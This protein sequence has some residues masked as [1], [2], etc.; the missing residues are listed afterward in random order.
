MVS[1]KLSI[2]IPAYNVEDYIEKCIT[3]IAEQ[4]V[5]N[6]FY[7][8]IIV[9][10]GST[11]NSRERILTL[12]VSYKNIVLVDQENKGVSMARNAGINKANGDYLVFVD[13]DDF[14]APG[15]L[16]SVLKHATF[17]KSQLTFLG[18]HSLEESI[19]PT[20]SFQFMQ[21]PSQ[22]LTGIE[23]YNTLMK[24]LPRDPDSSVAVLFQK[25]FLREY[26]LQFT[27]NIPYLEDCEFMARVFCLAT[28]CSFEPHPFYIRVTRPGS[29]TNSGLFYSE[30]AVNGFFFAAMHL[31]QFKASTLLSQAQ[32][33][34]I[35]QPITK[36]T[37]LIVQ[38]CIGQGRRRYQEIKKR[39]KQK[40]LD[41]TDLQGCSSFYY[42]YG[43]IYNISIDLFYGV[44]SARLIKISLKRRFQS[45][46]SKN[47]E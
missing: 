47:Y 36:F 34:H 22:I 46:L 38:S 19:T 30:A 20:L 11:D 29:A 13:A 28:S 45:R 31:K 24:N 39:L 42:K 32:K 17:A 43:V 18:F 15:S 21:D 26:G 1:K 33:Y 2:I 41:K 7:E 10:D 40:R 37:L 25:K 12:M 5:D 9:N 8:I 44:W 4:E 14:I 6:E 23:A 3:S 35:N 16:A 27:G